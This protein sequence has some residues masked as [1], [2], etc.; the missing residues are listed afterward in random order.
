MNLLIFASLVL[1]VVA[2][3]PIPAVDLN[4]SR[5]SG[6]WNVVWAFNNDWDSEMS[7]SDCSMWNLTVN[8]AT[9]E[10]AV[11]YEG[12]GWGIG[13]GFNYSTP[14]TIWDME[15]GGNVTWISF[16]LIDMQ[17]MTGVCSFDGILNRGFILSRTAHLNSI[18]LTWQIGMIKS[19]GFN[20]TKS[21]HH[22]Y[23]NAHNES[24]IE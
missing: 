2:Q 8:P 6:Q 18:I 20:V 12:S 5:I 16:D 9:N 10:I 24:C 4:I 19:E 3:N 14:N 21:N 1:I 22:F 17:W 13:F 7:F 11:L 23:K 15:F